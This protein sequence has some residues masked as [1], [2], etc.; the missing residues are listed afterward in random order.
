MSLLYLNNISLRYAEQP[1]LDEVE[2]RIN[3]QEKIALIGRNGAGKTTLLKLIAGEVE[4][5][6]GA[7]TRNSDKV[8]KM[9]QEN[10][11]DLEQTVNAY[12]CSQQQLS[13][14]AQPQTI[15]RIISQLQLSANA[16]LS[17]L[18]GG[19][20]RRVLLAAALVQEPDILLLDEPTNHMDLK[21]I[22]WLENFLQRCQLTVILI[23]HDRVFMQQVANR[24][25]EIDRGK[26][27]SCK[28]SYQQF[29]KFRQQ[30]LEAEKTAAAL[31]DKRLSEEEAWIRQG[32][33]ARRTRNE[34]RVRALKKMRQ[35]YAER[36]QQQGQLKLQQHQLSSSSKQ[37][38][39]ADNISYHYQGKMIFTDFSTIIHRQDRIG[40]IGPNGCGKTTLIQCLLG[41][42]QPTAGEVKLAQ[43]SVAYFDQHRQ[44]LDKQLTPIDIV[45]QGRQSVTI[46]GKDKHI[47]SYLQDFLFSPQQARAPITKLSGGECN[48]LLL[49]KLFTQPADLLVL[50][51]PTNDLDIESLELL[52]EYL[53]EYPGTIIVISHDREL[54]NNVVT[55][56]LVFKDSVITQYAGGYQDYLQQAQAAQTPSKSVNK[57]TK[58]ASKLSYD[59]RKELNRLPTK[60]INSNKKFKRK[61]KF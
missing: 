8:A 37:V 4:A 43:L 48:R 1:L 52:E 10:P 20:L 2:L 39:L 35:Q 12:L 40:I 32:I 26:L 47:I 46:N 55:S 34:G 5:D 61:D 60:L 28:G 27:R 11:T 14:W 42:L 15:E 6:S 3:D 18:S 16:T 53:S 9:A 19:Q 50:D 13:P 25:V 59:E 54:L 56:T 17:A 45:G 7:I 24:I 38:I 22:Q 29:L 21:T 33:K 44:Q 51:E 30:Q 49:A 41:Q 23:T 58:S 31:F 36:R 57:P